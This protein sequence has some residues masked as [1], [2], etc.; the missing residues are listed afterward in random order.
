MFFLFFFFFFFFN[1]TATTEIYTLSLHD[2]L[3]ILYVTDSGGSAEQDSSPVGALC[4][5]GAEGRGASV[6]RR[7]HVDPPTRV[8]RATTR[9]RTARITWPPSAPGPRRPGRA[10]RRPG[11]KQ[12]AGPPRGS[13]LPATRPACRSPPSLPA[14]RTSRAP[15][16]RPVSH[17][18]RRPRAPACWRD[19]AEHS[20]RAGGAH[21]WWRG[22]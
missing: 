22:R 14:A 8:A 16:A 10:S 21:A 2:A 1:D 13:A 4:E 9:G 20:R 19:R 15:P 11:S 17:R 7:S 3:P 12:P 18:R 5:L 6:G